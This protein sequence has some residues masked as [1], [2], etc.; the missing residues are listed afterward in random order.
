L[1]RRLPNAN[2]LGIV[3]AAKGAEPEVNAERAEEPGDIELVTPAQQAHIPP[4]KPRIP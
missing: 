1:I 3:R 2:I 4:S